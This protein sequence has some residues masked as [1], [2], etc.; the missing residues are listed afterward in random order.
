M[1]SLQKNTLKSV[2]IID[3]ID[4]LHTDSDCCSSFESSSTTSNNS[5]QEMI[6]NDVP[7]IL[8]DKDYKTRSFS[9]D[10]LVSPM[11][12]L[13][14]K[15]FPIKKLIKKKSSYFKILILISRDKNFFAKKVN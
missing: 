5:D 3:E 7:E 10:L 8:P 15:N 11:D 1:E 4:A 12:S 2:L 9:K 13:L 14:S 6:E